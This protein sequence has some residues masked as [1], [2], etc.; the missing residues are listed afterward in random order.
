MRRLAIP[1]ILLLAVGLVGLTGCNKESGGDVN[2]SSSTV[3]AS[4]EGPVTIKGVAFNPK[5]VHV[6]VGQ[7]LIWN[8][9]DGGLEHTVTADDKSFDSGRKSSGSWAQTFTKAGTIAYHCEV[10]SKMH[11]TI[12]VA[13]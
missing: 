9:E 2:I 10:H 7:E 12:V 4:G 13:G 8:W 3:P 6:K 11:G 1:A 5:E